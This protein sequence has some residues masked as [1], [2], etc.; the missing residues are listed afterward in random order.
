MTRDLKK[1]DIVKPEFSILKKGIDYQ[2]EIFKMSMTEKDYDAAVS[3]IEN[4]KTEIKNRA[5]NSNLDDRIKTVEEIIYWYRTIPFRYRKKTKNG[6]ILDLRPT[7]ELRTIQRLYK[8][9][10]EISTIL[11]IIKLL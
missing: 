3:S 5:I 8:A 6:M 9:Y 10:E 7:I 4:I 2:R 11:N 1:L